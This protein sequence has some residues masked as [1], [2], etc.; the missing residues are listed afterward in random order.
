MQLR[1][2]T[3]FQENIIIPNRAHSFVT[4][5]YRSIRSKMFHSGPVIKCQRDVIEQMH[6]DSS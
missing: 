2:A 1:R 5:Y 6:S 3:G 4:N